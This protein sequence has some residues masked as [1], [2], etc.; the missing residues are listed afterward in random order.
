MVYKALKEF[1]PQPRQ[2]DEK[3]CEL[4]AFSKRIQMFM[5]DKS[6]A[7]EDDLTDEFTIVTDYEEDKWD[8]KTI[9]GIM[10]VY[11]IRADKPKKGEEGDRHVWFKAYACSCDECQKDNTS[12]N[13]KN[14]HITGE[15]VKRKVVPVQVAPGADA[16]PVATEQSGA[17]VPTQHGGEG[18]GGG[19]EA[20]HVTISSGLGEEGNEEAIVN[21]ES[22]DIEDNETFHT[23]FCF[24]G[25]MHEEDWRDAVYCEDCG[26]WY[27]YTC[28]GYVE[29]EESKKL[30]YYC[31]DCVK[32]QRN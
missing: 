28:V 8:A 29:T 14:K 20:L 22:L 6:K 5:V 30:P 19:E 3:T 2:P 16:A 10:S 1:W 26:T 25:T 11:A 32:M 17:A 7:E 4:Y 12:K 18:E 9:A 21:M 31:E 24:C 13:C 27:H 15:W 23:G